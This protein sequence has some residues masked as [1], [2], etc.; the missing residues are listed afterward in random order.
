M[1]ARLV[2]SRSPPQPK[3]AITFDE[4]DRASAILRAVAKTR[5]TASGLWA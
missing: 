5:S 4:A 3:T 2:A 1:G